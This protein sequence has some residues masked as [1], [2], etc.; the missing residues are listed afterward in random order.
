[1][2]PVCIAT[3][4]WIAA[5]AGSTGGISALVVGRL[6][7]KNQQLTTKN[8]EEGERHEQGSANE[9]EDATGC[10]GAGVG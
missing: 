9:D 2:C 5:G 3:A 10:V 1:M 6:R 7:G 4:A 8:H